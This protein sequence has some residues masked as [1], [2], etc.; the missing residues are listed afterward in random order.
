[1]LL[2]QT[3]LKHVSQGSNFEIEL[4]AHPSGGYMWQEV[5]DNATLKLLNKKFRAL[6]SLKGSGGNDVFV[7]QA[8]KKGRTTIKLIYKQP[9]EK[10][11][12]EEKTIDV[13]I[14]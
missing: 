10:A 12:K 3:E 7:F 14:E 4:K 9:W 11:S 8:I 13:V 2:E 1:M 6:S 5:H